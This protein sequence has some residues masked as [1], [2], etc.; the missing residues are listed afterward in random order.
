[1]KTT[2]STI[3]SKGLP[4]YDKSNTISPTPAASKSKGTLKPFKVEGNKIFPQAGGKKGSTG[5]M[6]PMK[7]N[8]NNTITP[9][10][11]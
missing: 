8:K 3:K 4:S 2:T 9:T 5:E 1:M 7:Y 6:K 10:M 11:C